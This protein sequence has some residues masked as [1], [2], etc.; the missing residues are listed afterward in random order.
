MF[1]VNIN[2]GYCDTP[3]AIFKSYKGH[4]SQLSGSLSIISSD[5]IFKDKVN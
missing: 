4:K 5:F 1:I 3:S 2:V